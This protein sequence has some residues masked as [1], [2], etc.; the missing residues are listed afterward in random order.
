VSC[1]YAWLF[2]KCVFRTYS[3][4]LY[5]S[6]CT[7]H[8]SS[9]STGFTE[10]IMTILRILCYNGSLDIRMVISLTT[11]KFK[12]LIRGIFS[13]SLHFVLHHEHVYS[14][15]LCALPLIQRRVS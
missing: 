2:V 14:P 10:Q 9:A 1:E 4:L 7:T 5:S 12:S 3:M 6:F 11:A 13:V 15:D 8:Q